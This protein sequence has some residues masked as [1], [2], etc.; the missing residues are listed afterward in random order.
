LNSVL[1]VGG[2]LVAQSLHA[3]MKTV[4]DKYAVHSQ[5][6]YFLLAA[7]ADQN[8]IYHVTRVRDGKSFA[9]RT[10]RAVQGMVLYARGM[11]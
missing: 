10:V 6:C 3:A 11:R 4:P 8:I 9:T 5:H 7:K 2:Q 1:Y